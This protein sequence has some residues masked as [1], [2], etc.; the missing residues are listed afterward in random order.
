MKELLLKGTVHRFNCGG[1]QEL[2]LLLPGEEWYKAGVTPP[3]HASI[4]PQ[5]ASDHISKCVKTPQGQIGPRNP[6]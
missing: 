1:E 3:D 6:V 5:T 4:L 2:L